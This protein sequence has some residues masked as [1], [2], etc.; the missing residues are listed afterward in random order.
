MTTLLWLSRHPLLNDQL[1]DLYRIY[2]K[3]VKIVQNESSV[4][5]AKEILACA[6]SIN[7]NVIAVVLP[8]NLMSDMVNP[9]INVNNIPVIRSVVD[10]SLSDEQV[11]NPNTGTLE[12]ATII[13]HNHWERIVKIETVTEVL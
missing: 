3:D 9:R 7:A 4:S 13:K 5:S 1:A 6:E 12:Y 10:R 11:V 2:G 8:L